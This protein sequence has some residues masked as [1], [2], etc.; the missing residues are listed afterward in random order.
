MK[1]I[2]FKTADDYIGL[3]SEEKPATDVE[4]GSTFLEVD[5]GDTYIFY[6]GVWYKQ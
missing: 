2:T 3:S 5:K 1:K 6:D 4:D